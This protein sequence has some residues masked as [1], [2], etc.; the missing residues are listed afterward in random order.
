[1]Q[2]CW[3]GVYLFD[4][5]QLLASMAS[6]RHQLLSSFYGR[7]NICHHPSPCLV[8]RDVISRRVDDITPGKTINK[9]QQRYTFT[10]I[11]C[12]H[13]ASLR[14]KNWNI[15]TLFVCLLQNKYLPGWRRKACHHTSSCPVDRD[16][17]RNVLFLR[18]TYFLLLITLYFN[19]KNGSKSRIPLL[20]TSM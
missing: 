11:Y 17:L 12:A 1:M 10:N 14:S 19:W 20:V 6:W 18:C 13:T 8:D 2:N 4:T 5:G 7:R 9:N 15:N 3:S 16:V